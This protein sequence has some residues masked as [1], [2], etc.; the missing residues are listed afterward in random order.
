MIFKKMIIF[1]PSFERGGVEIILLNL[2]NHFLKKKIKIILISNVPKKRLPVD[3][4]FSQIKPKYK[5]NTFFSDRLHK[6]FQASWALAKLLKNS[7]SNETIVFSLQ[8]SSI[9]V[10]IS[11]FFNHKIAIR[12]AEDPIYSTIYADKKIMSVMS[13]VSKILTYNFSDKIIC[14]SIGSK[15]SL[16][17]ILLQKNKVISIYNPYLQRVYQGNASLK[18]NYALTVGRL[19]KQKDHQTL[20]KAMKILKDKKINFK[21]LIVGDGDQKYKLENL[22]KNLKLNKN[23][24]ILGWKKKINNYYKNAKLFILPSLYEG[25][26]NVVIDAVNYNVPVISTNCKSGPPEIIKKNKGGYLVPISNEYKIA[27]KIIYCLN[28]YDLANQKAKYAKK[29]LFRFD[30]N[31]NS[32]KYF[33]ELNKTF[34]GKE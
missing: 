27:K 22:I 10:P 6:A 32:E 20:I 31:K 24:K 18:K 2:I 4:N 11:K 33:Q 5:T 3:N 1:Y 21:L 25:L 12:N 19:T 30:R 13:I 14:N 17:K 15:I 29:Y 26:G 23:I 28:N 34:Y 8:S 16:K 9:A 7:K